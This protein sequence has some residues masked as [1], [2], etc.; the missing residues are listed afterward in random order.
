MRWDDAECNDYIVP[1][2][3][4]NGGNLAVEAHNISVVSQFEILLL[5]ATES[6]KRKLM[7]KIV[8]GVHF[9]WVF[10]CDPNRPWSEARNITKEVHDAWSLL[11]WSH[12]IRNRYPCPNL[13]ELPLR[14]LPAAMFGADD[15]IHRRAGHPME[16]D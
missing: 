14:K 16:M 10:G 9:R 11:V 6:A 5:N 7:A 15:D 2:T 12:Q 13:R 8:A 4:E 3:P 1:K